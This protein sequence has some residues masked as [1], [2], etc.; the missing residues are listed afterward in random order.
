MAISIKRSST[1]RGATKRKA[2][3]ER[4]QPPSNQRAVPEE[5]SLRAQVFSKYLARLAADE[6]EVRQFRSEYLGGVTLLPADAAQF[7]SEH[8]PSPDQPGGDPVWHELQRVSGRLAAR[9]PWSTKQAA[10]FLVTGST[11]LVG[12][13]SVGH[14]MIN[15]RTFNHL[16]LD[17]TVSPWVSPKTVLKVYREWRQRILRQAPRALGK[18]SLMF[19]DFIS[20]RIQGTPAPPTWRSLTAEWNRLHPDLR[21]KDSRHFARD[22]RRILQN[23]VFLNMGTPE[24]GPP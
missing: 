11:P 5:E 3:A 14:G 10:S 17:L 19:F 6:Y 15:S 9:F 12:A 1:K 18:N 7:E 16:R 2:R 22:Y 20:E 8:R 23:V 24:E 4:G 13:V 21:Y